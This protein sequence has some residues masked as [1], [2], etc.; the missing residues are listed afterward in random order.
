MLFELSTFSKTFFLGPTSPLR[1]EMV[2]QVQ[3]ANQIENKLGKGGCR[4]EI[5]HDHRPARATNMTELVFAR[6]LHHCHVS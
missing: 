5:S 4:F 3:T 2:S 6:K 1:P